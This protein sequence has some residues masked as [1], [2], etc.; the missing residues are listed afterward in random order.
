M[1]EVLIQHRTGENVYTLAYSISE[2]M[3]IV[4][5]LRHA[6]HEARYRARCIDCGE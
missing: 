3:D 6:G 1:Y 5:S 4:R 2:A